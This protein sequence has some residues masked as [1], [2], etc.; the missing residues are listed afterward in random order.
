MKK[1]FVLFASLLILFF[2]SEKFC[3][4]QSCNY[5]DGLNFSQL[6]D[7]DIELGEFKHVKDDKG[8]YEEN[9]SPLIWK[10]LQFDSDNKNLFLINKYAVDYKIY[11]NASNSD[12]DSSDLKNWLDN[13]F[14]NLFGE[15]LK[16]QIKN[17]SL[18]YV[19]N[20]NVYVKDGLV[21][22]DWPLTCKDSQNYVDWWTKTL[23][24]DTMLKAIRYRNSNYKIGTF[25]A[26]G[27]L[28]V[29]PCMDLDLNNIIYFDS[30]NCNDF[31]FVVGDSVGKID[32]ICEN[33]EINLGQ[34]LNLNFDV[35]D[36][37]DDY[38]VVYKVVS[39]VEILSHETIENKI[40]KTSNLDLGNYDVY[41]W[42]Q[43]KEMNF[44]L[45]SEPK[46]FEL[47]I[48][49]ANPEIFDVRFSSY[50]HRKNF[51][52]NILVDVSGKNFK[53]NDKMQIKFFDGNEEKFSM[54]KFIEDNTE[55]ISFFIE[56]DN[57]CNLPLGNYNIKINLSRD[58]KI[59]LEK[60]LDFNY[61]VSDLPVVSEIVLTPDTLNISLDKK[62]IDFCMKLDAMQE[63]DEVVSGAAYILN[64]DGEKIAQC[65]DFFDGGNNNYLGQIY[66]P[67]NICVGNYKFD[68]QFKIKNDYFGDEHI[69][70]SS[71]INFLI[72][73]LKLNQPKVNFPGGK[74][75]SAKR[76]ILE[77]DDDAKIFY[78][79][80]GSM[81]NESSNI[82]DKSFV[83]G[84]GKHNLKAIAIKENY[85]ASQILE[86]SYNIISSSSSNDDEI[87]DTDV[88]NEEETAENDDEKIKE[89]ETTDEI[90]FYPTKQNLNSLADKN[91]V[92]QI[93]AQA[94]KSIKLN[95][96]NE[97]VSY[98][99]DNFSELKFGI[100]NFGYVK[101]S[102]DIFKDLI[103]HDI[104]IE[105]V[106]DGFAFNVKVDGEDYVSS[107]N[108][109][110]ISF[111]YNAEKNLDTDS[112][113]VFRRVADRNKIVAKSFYDADK[114]IMSCK[115]KTGGTFGVV[116]NKI[117]FSDVNSK[118]IAY[119]AARNILN[120]VGENK[121][122]PN[123]N[124]KRADFLITLMRI[125]DIQ[126]DLLS[127]NFS[128][129]ENKYYSA[130]TATAKKLKLVNG[131][132]E[133]KFEPENF[134]TLRDMYFMTNNFFG[135][136]KLNF[137]ENDFVKR[138]TAA[139][140][141]FEILKSSFEN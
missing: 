57:L 29:R 99:A 132:G 79:L 43:K 11:S 42:L 93:D 59:L 3:L 46:K 111:A 124:I 121:F 104:S 65:E 96:T 45:T 125:L 126:P 112:L 127:D 14:L 48:L 134:L 81:P 24:N 1:V 94:Q 8:T 47:K 56:K 12:W 97:I 52:K 44:N 106:H 86:Q 137:I 37:Q 75:F 54:D 73:Q 117:V 130:Y 131:V 128:D 83:L 28:F 13:D 133:N 66:L 39:N 129:C 7:K 35:I 82:F 22:E 85:E 71:T 122:L 87:Y 49:E 136:T 123:A 91:K 72:S 103:G 63:N 41:V 38:S 135:N 67:D 105:I 140:F 20:N 118:E 88:T 80:D 30:D 33:Y 6:I 95:L 109:F 61:V 25:G 64:S 2:I 36:A 23:S 31:S 62:K 53:A 100:K 115:T 32:D 141:L 116:Y 68:A 18:P 92:V 21:L 108:E 10:V 16:S 51:E 40:M 74:Y 9:S 114:K 50:A 69:I 90:D 19:E 89:V 77:S 119:L 78:T 60:D 26:D 5:N 17:L 120:G 107:K 138:L 102:Q 110:E 101:V 98:I 139:K 34:D 15:N 113:V 27:S 84:N 4:T 76:I 58:N 55:E 70:Y